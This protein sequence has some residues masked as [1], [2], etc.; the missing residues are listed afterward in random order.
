MAEYENRYASRGV[1]G[2]GLGLG[3]AG[4]ALGVMNGGL[5]NIFGGWNNGCCSD[6][7]PVNRY[8]LSQEQKISELQ[9][10]IAL[11]DANVFVDSKILELYKYVDGK[12]TAVERELCDQ[13]VYNAT[14]TAT[15]GCIANQVNQLMAL[16]KLVVPNSSICPGWGTATVTV[17]SGTTTA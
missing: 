8:E 15:I 5:G 6:N 10:Q 12:F 2:A 11:R 7:M 13:K 3:I 1:G 16:T 14:N 9:S 17:A 4:T